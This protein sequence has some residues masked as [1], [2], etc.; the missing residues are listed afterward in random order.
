M[1][2]PKSGAE[3]WILTAGQN[4]LKDLQRSCILNL[5]PALTAPPSI[6]VPTFALMSR[7]L[8]SHVVTRPGAARIHF[9]APFSQGRPCPRSPGP[10][11]LL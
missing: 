10:G 3:R 2:P 9:D 8:T 5:I 6:N 11:S 7:S 4:R 1:L